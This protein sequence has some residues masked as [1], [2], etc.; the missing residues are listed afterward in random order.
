MSRSESKHDLIDQVEEVITRSGHP[1]ANIPLVAGVSGG[2]DSMVMLWIMAL[3]LKK[4]VVVGHINYGQRGSDS[5]AD[6]QLVR[7]FCER[8]GIKVVVHH[9]LDDSQETAATVAKSTGNFQDR[10]RQ[11]RRVFLRS[12]MQEY[13]AH[14]IM[15]AHHSD[16]QLETIFQKMLRGAAPEK[17]TGMKPVDMP[18]VRPL[19]YAAKSEV[20]AFAERFGIP[21][22]IDT[23][24]LETSYARNTLRNQVFP[25]LDR[26]F[27]GWQQNILRLPDAAQRYASMLELTLS[28]IAEHVGKS[29]HEPGTDEALTAINRRSWLSLPE[30]L[31]L[32][33][34]RFWI[35]K[36]TGYKGWSS[37]EVM[38]LADMEH[39]QTGSSID[40]GTSF[41]VKRDRDRFV[42]TWRQKQRI[43]HEI[44]LAD[45]AADEQVLQG[46]CFSMDRYDPDRM[47]QALQLRADALPEKLC[48]RT[49]QHGD[50]IRPLGMKGTQSIA[51]HL[52]NKKV[53][54][55]QKSKTLV[56]VSFDGKVHAVIFP[57]SPK[58]GEVGTIT[59]DARCYSE[60]QEILL[61]TKADSFS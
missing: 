25:V 33:V 51:D 1:P 35:E 53:P 9:F 7:T 30:E 17:W 50:R 21:Y 2:V 24:N 39:L 19:L 56:L 28:R 36:Q 61:I 54:L 8:H 16:D 31:R 43:C 14:A 45:V 13:S 52:T 27:A 4:R 59:E 20:I 34:A 32:P 40:M 11:V 37:G 23:S 10:A 46:L 60:G 55:V 12:V 41:I 18:W 3:K 29:I 6:E 57:H 47:E 15:L 26:T 22:R 38:R 5:T 58:T 42:L 49:W 48:L 44:K